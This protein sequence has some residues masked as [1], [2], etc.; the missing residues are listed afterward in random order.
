MSKGAQI[1]IGVV[2][3]ALLLGWY[4]YTNLQGEASFQYYQ[5]LGEFLAKSS[6]LEGESLRVHGYV[7]NDSIHRDL[8]GK[9]VR[10]VVQN[11]P[12]HAGLATEST[13]DV[14]FLGLETPDMFKDGAEVVIEGRVQNHQTGTVFLADNLMAKCP[15]KFEAQANQG[16]P[17][18]N[19]PL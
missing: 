3:V 14:L 2:I 19:M 1:T 6:T 11:D 9:K 8:K 15:S 17:G 18:G 10:F 7:A 4:G 12:P 5:N 13:L 16:E